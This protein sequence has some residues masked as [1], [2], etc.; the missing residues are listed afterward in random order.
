MSNPREYEIKPPEEVRNSTD[1]REAIVL[2]RSNEDDLNE[3]L[4]TNTS[5]QR[6][7]DRKV[8]QYVNRGIDD[9][10]LR[11]LALIAARNSILKIP[12]DEIS[13]FLPYTS[14]AIDNEIRCELR[15]Q[16][17]GTRS[18]WNA[19]AEFAKAK[20]A[21]SQELGR[22]STDEEVYASL[23]WNADQISK[24]QSHHT[25]KLRSLGELVQQGGG[26][27]RVIEISDTS[28]PGWGSSHSADEQQIFAQLESHLEAI[29]IDE[30]KL[31]RARYLEKTGR[32]KYA[33]QQGLT[34]HRVKTKEIQ[35]LASLKRAIENGD[36]MNGEGR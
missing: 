29:P 20:S 33:R 18:Q 12:L 17:F 15:K 28:I 6:L 27:K 30:E 23:D 26:D 16:S 5:L 21:L 32:K 36:S 4:N 35:A 9:D 25:N 3:I 11:Q 31:L 14:K 1:L 10:E 19:I 22:Q 7:L 2:A 8:R 13:C 24:H 34:E